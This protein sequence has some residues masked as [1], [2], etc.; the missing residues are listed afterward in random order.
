MSFE[1]NYKKPIPTEQETRANI[2]IVA[3]SIGCQEQVKRIFNFFDS[4][5]AKEKNDDVARQRIVE[6]CM[7]ELYKLDKRLV[8]F[9]VNENGE[10]VVGNKVLIKLF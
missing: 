7:L 6:S 3:G 9:F 5:L 1:I 2:L 10:I 8:S 4:Q